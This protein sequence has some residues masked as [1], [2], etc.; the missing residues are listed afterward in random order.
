MSE[1]KRPS[2]GM[3]TPKDFLAKG[4]VVNYRER[5]GREIGGGVEVFFFVKR[6]GGEVF[7]PF[8]EGGLQFFLAQ[9]APF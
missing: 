6:G 7:S 4:V 5:G 3:T 1:A 8:Q 2:F 9:R